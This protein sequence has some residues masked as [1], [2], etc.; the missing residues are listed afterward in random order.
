[1]TTI[2]MCSNSGFEK[3]QETYLFLR[4]EVTG[5]RDFDGGFEYVSTALGRK[6]SALLMFVWGI[7]EQKRPVVKSVVHSASDD[8]ADALGE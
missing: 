5:H 1:M 7:L 8:S 6:R 2:G 3:P 4:K